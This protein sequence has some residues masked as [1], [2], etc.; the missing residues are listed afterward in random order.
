M[1]AL[2]RSIGSHLKV[3]KA[4]VRISLMNQLEYRANFF[5]S[6][7]VELCFFF[8]KML[9]VILVYRAGKTIAGYTPDMVLLYVGCFVLVTAFYVLLFMDNFYAIPGMIRDGSLDLL[10]AKPV[11][12]QFIVTLRK[13][14]FALPIPNLIGGTAMV[15]VAWT[16]LGIPVTPLRIGIFAAAIAGGVALAYSVFLFPQVLAF[17]TVKNQ[18]II[19]IA[20]RCWDFNNMPMAIYGKWFRRFGL[21]VIPVFALTNFPAMYLLGRIKPLYV[22]WAALSPILFFVLVRALWQVGIK[23]YGSAGG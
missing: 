14:N 17:W 8:S 4:F 22:V 21:F 23:K 12:L 5:T 10:I 16:R 1:A 19:D 18:A 2:F 11:S 13:L 6:L 3:Y 20:D 9:Y 7:A 15:V